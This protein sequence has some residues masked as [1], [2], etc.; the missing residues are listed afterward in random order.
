MT[1]P[2]SIDVIPT[3][4]VGAMI[5]GVDIAAGLDDQ[6]FTEL[7]EAFIEHGVIFLRDQHITPDQHV[8]FAHRWGEINVN[9]F[10]RPVD[11]HPLIAEVRKDPGQTRNIGADWHTDHSYDQIPALGSILYARVVP[12]TGGDT[13][14]TNMYRAYE[15]LSDGMKDTLHRLSADHSSRHQFGSLANI[16]GDTHDIGTRLGNAE[17]A[18]QDAVHPV[19]IRHP[20][21]GRPALYVNSDF[22]LRLTGWT[23]EESEPLLAQLYA[24]A[25]R[26]EFQYRFSWEV[27]S[28][29]IW[30][31][32]ATLHVAANDYQGELRLMHRI[33]IEGEALEPFVPA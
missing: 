17:A 29:A 12:P 28:M 9:R 22:V 30:D 26:E 8:E 23:D 1:L 16:E 24:H 19:V 15:T 33:T 5:D 21:S 13:L 4:T 20:L 25:V 10:F 31:N 11:G 6:Q 18:T 27:G 14:F 32:R 2:T 7:R 3:G